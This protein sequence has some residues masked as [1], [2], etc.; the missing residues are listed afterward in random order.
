MARLGGKAPSGIGLRPVPGSPADPFTPALSTTCIWNSLS[1]Y[2][3]NVC[4]CVWEHVNQRFVFCLLF[5]LVLS[6]LYCNA[7]GT[8]THLNKR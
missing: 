3:A 7:Q 8:P 6:T 2:W 1:T 4:V 5:T